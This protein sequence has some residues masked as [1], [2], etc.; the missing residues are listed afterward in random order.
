[1]NPL[2]ALYGGAVATRNWMYDRGL[3]RTRELGA[4]VVSIGNIR[5]G[6]AGKTPFTVLLGELLKQRGVALDVLSRGYKRQTSG[7]QVVDTEGSA[8][9]FGDEP[10]LIAKRLRVPV[11]VA[12][13][14]YDAG[15]LGEARFQSAMHLL[16]DGFQH[17]ELVR[18]FDVVLVDE[19]DLADSLLP[20]GRLREPASE[21]RRADVLVVPAAASVKAFEK[22]GKPLWRVQ[23]K[24]RTPASAPSRPVVF[25]GLAKPD[26][27]VSDIRANRVEPACFVTFPDHHRYAEKDVA[28]LRSVMDR[29]HADGFIT[30]E[31]DL[32]NLGRLAGQLPGLTVAIL[33]VELFEA[34]SCVDFLLE[35]I[36]ARRKRRS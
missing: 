15:H 25:C 18:Q 32:M 12:A 26:R 31:K 16:D 8:C 28:E 33:Q 14:R 23:R 7:V 6:G 29:N 30:T 20:T 17:R 3:L 19:A 9:D 27:F 21:L 5:V 11:I 34:E 35:T 24:L 10:L 36:A 2:S 1:V 22:F 4:P 13:K